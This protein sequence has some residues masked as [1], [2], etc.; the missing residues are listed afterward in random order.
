MNYK[1]NILIA[2]LGLSLIV[3]L[4]LAWSTVPVQ[5]GPELPPR[6]PLP[7][8]PPPSGDDDDDDD[9]TVGA[10]IELEAPAGAAGAWAVVQWQDRAGNWHDVAGWRGTMVNSS[11]WWVHPK[12]FG[13]GPFRWVVRQGPDG[14]VVQMSEPFNLPG[15]AGETIRVPSAV[16]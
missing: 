6:D 11:H 13:T 1:R 7:I 2:V 8:Q 10:Y 3:A 15:R 16:K 5:A 4:A 9:R 14:P 12:D